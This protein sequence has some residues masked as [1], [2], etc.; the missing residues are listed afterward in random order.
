MH[1]Q[2]ATY[3]M[4]DISDADFIEANQEFAAMM[5]AVPGLLAKVWLKDPD[6]NVYGGIYFWQDREACERFLASDLWASVVNDDSLSDLESRSF[7][8]MEDLTRAT[9]PRMKLL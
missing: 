1:V 4:T 2:V 5:S 6:A 7:A 9:Q 8:V 3:R